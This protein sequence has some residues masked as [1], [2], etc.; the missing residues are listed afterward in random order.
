MVGQES[1][2][3]SAFI[4]KCN[5]VLTLVF[6]TVNQGGRKHPDH[7]IDDEIT[8]LH[9]EVLSTRVAARQDV[10]PVTP[11]PRARTLAGSLPHTHAICISWAREGRCEAWTVSQSCP[12]GGEEVHPARLANSKKPRKRKKGKL[13]EDGE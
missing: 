11:T 7:L 8:A 2:S 1:L 9:K 4:E 5:G 12:A 6:G 3:N 13:G 10:N